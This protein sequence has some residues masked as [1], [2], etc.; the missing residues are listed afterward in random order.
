MPIKYEEGL[1]KFL[2]SR[3]VLRYIYAKDYL[4]QH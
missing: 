3:G 1:S 2:L 4:I